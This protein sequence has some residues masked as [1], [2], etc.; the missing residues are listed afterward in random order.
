M[1]KGLYVLAL[2]SWLFITG[3]G[4]LTGEPENSVPTPDKNFNATFIDNQDVIVRCTQISMDGEVFIWGKK[5]RGTVTISF[6]KIKTIEFMNTDN[7][8]IAE[9]ELKDGKREK[10]E[11]DNKKMFYGNLEFGTFQIEVRDLKKIVF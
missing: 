5:G 1:K 6:E 9:V 2:C 4:E 11:V 8:I 7:S 10:I 3:M